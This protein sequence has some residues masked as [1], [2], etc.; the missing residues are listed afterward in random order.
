MIGAL[1]DTLLP[2]V[3]LA[4]LTL[5][6][7]LGCCWRSGTVVLGL[8]AALSSQLV[9]GPLL[10]TLE[11]SR[12]TAIT[13]GGSPDA[14]VILPGDRPI[15][16]N[17]NADSPSPGTLERL[18]VGAALERRTALPILV[19]GGRREGGRASQADDMAASLK[20]DFRVQVRWTE[21]SSQNVW[22]SAAKSAAML[23]EAGI[24]RVYLVTDLPEVRLAGVVFRKAGL[25]VTPAPVPRPNPLHILPLGILP[26]ADTWLD[27]ARSLREWSSLACDA[28]AP[29]RGMALR[30]R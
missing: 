30:A 2:P 26:L 24:T 18:R 17:P 16:A 10:A 6:L 5:A 25:E 29:C 1:V 22:Q 28:L 23:R 21:T 12:T 15:S 19:T 8:L 9:S 4:L 11:P 20:D 3:G 27:S 13:Q 7:L 14:I